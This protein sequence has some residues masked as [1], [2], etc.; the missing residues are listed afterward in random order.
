MSDT[1]IE[2]DGFNDADIPNQ[3]RELLITEVDVSD[4]SSSEISEGDPDV[5]PCLPGNRVT[6]MTT[7]AADQRESAPG[8]IS[9]DD[10]EGFS[11]NDTSLL[12]I[13]SRS[14]IDSSDLDISEVHTSDL[15]PQSESED[16][17]RGDLALP[18]AADLSDSQ[19][20]DA[21]DAD[22]DSENSDNEVNWTRHTHPININDFKESTG[23]NHNLQWDASPLDYFYLM[24]SE[25]TFEHIVRETNRY[26]HA[27][28]PGDK[29]WTPI[30]IPELKAYFGIQIIMGIHQ[31]P[32][33]WCYWSGEDF[34]R[35]DAVANIMSKSRYEKIS[36]YF[37]V[38]SGEN[39]PRGTP[40][41]DPIHK[42]RKIFDI[43]VQNFQTNYDPS[44]ELSVD[45]AMIGFKGR[46]HFKQYMPAKPT[47][48]GIK[49]WELANS[50][51]GYILNMDVYTGKSDRPTVDGRGLGHKVVSF[52]TEPFYNKYHHVYFDNFFTSLDLLE[53]LEENGTYACGTV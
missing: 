16:S 27:K 3:E 20:D 14:T 8:D 45:E 18:E 48:W 34:L 49:I 41:H 39:A 30:T 25:D 6:R 10:F 42:V 37:H 12:N 24:F 7:G 53:D 9:S 1:E 13:S 43:A 40:G 31:L 5:D 47:K 19:V 23:P 33:Y 38:E 44:R 28:K 52:L 21:V 32:A 2:F 51:N 36:E 17:D 26:Q 4:V 22:A 11:A 29:Y 35:V 15:S 46:L 50:S